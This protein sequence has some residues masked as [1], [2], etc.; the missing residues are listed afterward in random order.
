MTDPLPPLELT[1][2]VLEAF[3]HQ[4]TPMWVFDF[5]E[6]THPWA[7]VAGRAFFMS[8]SLA[9]FRARGL[10]TPSIQVRAET[11][12][13]GER[14]RRGERFQHVHT[15]TPRGVRKQA[16]VS[17][18]PARWQGRLVAFVEAW[19]ATSGVATDAV[20]P[21][22]HWAWSSRLL[23]LVEPDGR[24]SELNP[25]AK[26]LLGELQDIAELSA[27][28]QDLD[29]ILRPLPAGQTSRR[30][31]RSEAL[32]SWLELDLSWVQDPVTGKRRLLVEG[33]DV[34]LDVARREA[35][36]SSL[37]F[38]RNVLDSLPLPT[39]VLD[40]S[41]RVL[42]ANRSTSEYSGRPSS[43]AVGLEIWDFMEPQEAEFLRNL[44]PEA[45]ELGH[46][47]DTEAWWTFPVGRRY[48]ASST[49]RI[50]IAGSPHLIIVGT[51]LTKLKE[52]SQ[53]LEEARAHAEAASRAKS[54]FLASVTHELRT[55]LNGVLGVAEIASGSDDL[56][57]IHEL[58]GHIQ[59]AGQSLLRLIDDLLLYARL[60]SDR[61]QIARGSVP[62]GPFFEQLRLFHQQTAT[63]AGL[64]LRLELD[65]ELPEHI[66]LDEVRVRQVIQNL[67]S[68][69]IKFSG[70]GEV[71]LRAQCIKPSTLR[72][73]VQDEGIGIDPEQL[74]QLFEAFTQAD[75]SISK[76]FGGTGLGLAVTKRLVQAMEGEIH[77]QSQVG[78]GSL[79]VVDI[80]AHPSG[81]PAPPPSSTLGPCEVLVVEDNPVNRLVATRFLES[82]GHSVRAVESGEFAVQAV[83]DQAPD[84][85]LL[86][87]HMPGM[88]GYQT[89]QALLELSPGLPIMA[90]TAD[91]RP[92][93]RA[94]CYDAGMTGYITKPLSAEELQHALEVLQDG[95]P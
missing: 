88:D 85:V 1:E 36:E 61:L 68:N 24:I 58:L 81:P 4:A 70:R 3:E 60:G 71:V 27:D 94:A 10:G 46:P 23:M 37:T 18:R 53:E 12:Q 15:F 38:L 47:H 42:M 8:P 13:L 93:S 11:A 84:L 25:A 20:Q 19:P 39:I 82:R 83:Q 7:N 95:S 5:Q 9:E 89:A 55:P 57:E 54:E 65:P 44:G 56:S 52:H 92:E 45:L 17:V 14:M 77:V 48:F 69:A 90:M 34:G 91:L 51:D 63:Q 21:P 35:M 66:C 22:N 40:S 64:T 43:A 59:H 30:L 33:R 78:E 28:P 2:A 75:A 6:F 72:I 50:N 73:S 67:L 26:D 79:F 29:F 49:T 31:V 62:T 87:L 76:R 86:D 74:P 41:L 32:D 80:P 16:R